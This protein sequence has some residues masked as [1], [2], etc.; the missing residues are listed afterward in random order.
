MYGWGNTSYFSLF[1]DFQE[2]DIVSYPEKIS[3]S[4]FYDCLNEF[5]KFSVDSAISSKN[6]ESSLIK[7]IKRGTTFLKSDIEIKFKY[8]KCEENFSLIVI[9]IILK[10]DNDNELMMIN[11]I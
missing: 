9:S 10:Y 4:N 8:V 7:I 3:S 2:I 5:Y 11:L 1:K 6:P